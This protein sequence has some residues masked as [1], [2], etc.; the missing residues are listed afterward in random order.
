MASMVIRLHHCCNLLKSTSCYKI[1]TKLNSTSTFKTNISSSHIIYRIITR[2]LI[3]KNPIRYSNDKS[4]QLKDPVKRNDAHLTKVLENKQPSQ[5]QES[6]EKDI[7]LYEQMSPDFFGKLSIFCLLQ[8]LFFTAT[9][10]AFTGL[11]DAPVKN[12]DE[13]GST[14]DMSTSTITLSSNIN[15]LDTKSST[16]SKDKEE[17]PFW[18]K[19]NL[20]E[21]KIKRS[22]QALFF[23]LGNNFKEVF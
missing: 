8:F 9:S 15:T 5:S 21:N 22:L 3:S 6:T 10:F 7:L 2:T 14:K 16:Q 1:S 12:N 20:G 17:L 4:A 18:R 11:R 23:V 13:S 19:I